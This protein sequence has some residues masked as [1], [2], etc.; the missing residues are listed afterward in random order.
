MR[1]LFITILLLLCVQFISAQQY[2]VKYRN[3]FG[4]ALSPVDLGVGA[5]YDVQLTPRSGIYST[6]TKGEFR[7]GEGYI[8]D[9]IR[10]AAGY[11]Y[12]PFN[13]ITFFSVGVAYNW[14]GEVQTAPGFNTGVMKPPVS[15][16]FGFG[17]RIDRFTSAV[18]IDPF[19]RESSISV[20]YLFNY[21][22]K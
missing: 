21:R 11:N 18:H 10:A 15:G 17:T 20:A 6:L 7:F 19:K 4:I 14:Y 2:F 22:R 5:S 3:A 13:S 9:H 8:K 16:E 12:Y 1:K